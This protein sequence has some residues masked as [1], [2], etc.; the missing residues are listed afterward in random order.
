MSAQPPVSQSDTYSSIGTGAT[1]SDS[2][3]DQTRSDESL[4]ALRSAIQ[5]ASAAEIAIAS[6]MKAAG[7]SFPRA[8]ASQA[9]EEVPAQRPHHGAGNSRDRPAQHG[10]AGSPYRCSE[11]APVTMR[12]PK[13]QRRRPAGRGRQLIGHQLPDREQAQ[14]PGRPPVARKASQVPPR[15][16]LPR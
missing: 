14:D 6:S 16:S 13:T 10:A 15:W 5:I 1:N 8:A 9:A 7:R 4:A 2:S 11:R 12:P 3:Q